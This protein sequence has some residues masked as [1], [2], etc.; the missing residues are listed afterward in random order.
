MALDM[1]PFRE[2]LE[3]ALRRYGQQYSP[4]IH[5]DEQVHDFTVTPD[6]PNY[7]RTVVQVH[8]AGNPA[9]NMYVIVFLP[10]DGTGDESTYKKEEVS[11]PQL[12]FHQ[13]KGS[14][15]IPRAK[16]GVICEGFFPLLSQKAD[17]CI[18]PFA[19]SLE[20]LTLDDQNTVVPAWT[21]GLKAE[22]Y[23]TALQEN[24]EVP[25]TTYFTVGSNSVGRRFGDPH[26]V[27][28]R[29]HG[30]IIQVAGFL[31]ITNE[32]SPLMAMTE[33]W[34]RPEGHY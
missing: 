4:E 5:F 22:P 12:F 13:D 3:Y 23:L 6:K 25:P 18:H 17:G 20:E 8:H 32:K 24:R 15:V 34:I 26:S 16:K 31:A 28:H 30:Q 19:V 27:Y 10:G 11:I 2:P 7:A 14:R 33:R 9:G 1:Q 21:L 29:P